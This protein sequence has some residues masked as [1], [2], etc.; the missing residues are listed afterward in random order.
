MADKMGRTMRARRVMLG[1][2]FVISGCARGAANPPPVAQPPGQTADCPRSGADATKAFRQ[3]ARGHAVPLPSLDPGYPDTSDLAHIKRAVGDAT[4]VLLSEGCHNNR[5]FMLLHQRVIR[6]LVQELGFNTVVSESGLP[7]SFI[8]HDY[9]LGAPAPEQ[10]W[11]N[12]LNK[13]YSAWA[14]GRALIEWLRQHNQRHRDAPVRYYGVDIAGFYRDWRPPLRLVTD[15]LDRVDAAYSRTLKE[16]IAPLLEILGTDARKRHQEVLTAAQRASLTLILDAAVAQIQS[17][18][19]TYLAKT[20]AGAYARALRTAVALQQADTYYNNHR[21]RKHPETSKSVGLNGRELAMARNI[22][23]VMK[24]HRGARVIAINHVIHT[25]TASGP[26]EGIWGH[27]T[28]MGA[29]LKEALGDRMVA[30]GMVYGGGSY[31][32]DWQEPEKRVVDT[33]PEA[34]ADGM[35]A[36]LGGVGPAN[37]FINFRDAPPGARAWL[38]RPTTLRENDYYTAMTPGEWDGCFYIDRATPATPAVR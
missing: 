14:E 23:W 20:D 4:L 26:Q 2:V 31:W 33:I 13:M 16:K 22:L 30:I 12:G 35:E 34:R 17:R 36:T 6:Y 38:E 10:M 3:W 15:Y 8:I 24:Q 19:T 9:V 28:P 7:E 18:R 11:R 25:K 21:Q 27:F 1:A 29:L 37:Y 5:Q 32:K